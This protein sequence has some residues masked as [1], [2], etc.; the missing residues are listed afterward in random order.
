MNHIIRQNYLGSC[1]WCDYQWN[2]FISESISAFLDKRCQK[3]GL[4][5]Y[6]AK[7]RVMV[8]AVVK[9]EPANAK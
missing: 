4:C 8:T 6:L 1:I 3:I 5:S 7:Q 2:I 9:L